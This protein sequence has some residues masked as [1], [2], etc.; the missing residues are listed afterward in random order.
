MEFSISEISKSEN[1]IRDT[2]IKLFLSISFDVSTPKDL[3]RP[4]KNS[5]V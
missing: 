4:L 2:F 1:S 5:L 3:F